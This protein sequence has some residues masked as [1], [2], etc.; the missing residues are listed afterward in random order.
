MSKATRIR[1]VH[2]ESLHSTA[3]IEELEGQLARLS[4]VRP[5]ER[6]H[7]DPGADRCLIRLAEL[8]VDVP[9]D[10]GRLARVLVANHEQ[11]V[12]LAFLVL[13]AKG[14]LSIPQPVACSF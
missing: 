1:E 9:V 10:D 14:N 4:V 5:R 8:V 12:V 6:S 13:V 11:L 3:D 2:N 7:V